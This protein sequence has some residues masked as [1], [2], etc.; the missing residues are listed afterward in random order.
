MINGRLFLNMIKER[1][2]LNMII[3]GDNCL[4]IIKGDYVKK[5]VML[6]LFIEENLCFALILK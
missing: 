3:Q 6:V 2:C 5:N 1:L 4:N